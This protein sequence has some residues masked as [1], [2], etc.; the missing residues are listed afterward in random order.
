MNRD[1][2]YSD[3]ESTAED[4]NVTDFEI[5]PYTP[6]SR[7]D[8]FELRFDGI[9]D[10]WMTENEMSSLYGILKKTVNY[11]L[12]KAF[13]DGNLD[14]KATCQ[15]YW[16]V[17]NEGGKE[18]KREINYYNTDAIMYV[19][20][21]TKSKEGLMFRK[22][23][24]QF[25]KQRASQP[26]QLT[27]QQID[28]IRLQLEEEL[29]P[30]IRWNMTRDSSAISYNIFTHMF[31][32][33]LEHRSDKIELLKTDTRSLNF[34]I[35]GEHRTNISDYANPRQLQALTAARYIYVTLIQYGK[36]MMRHERLEIVS[37]IIHTMFPDLRKEKLSELPQQRKRITTNKTIFTKQIE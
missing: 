31:T 33:K 13:K 23:I 15:Q 11:H 32:N 9:D 3:K 12:N 21:K 24:T 16:L 6:N 30:E 8:T 28:M 19:G 1:H 20:F 36:E 14:K 34:I 26:S 27:Q 25:I 37:N 17:Q 29:I 10:F 35:F 22:N 5:I 7:T 4:I 18:V 2:S